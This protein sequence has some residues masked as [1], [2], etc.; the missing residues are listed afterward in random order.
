MCLG[1]P[2]T[3]VTC[4]NDHTCAT[5]RALR[6]LDK[7]NVKPEEHPT[8]AVTRIPWPVGRVSRPGP[9]ERQPTGR[10]PA[11]SVS[12]QKIHSIPQ[13]ER[14]ATGTIFHVIPITVGD[15]SSVRDCFVLY[16]IQVTWKKLKSARVPRVIFP[17][18]VPSCPSHR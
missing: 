5:L 11:I 3:R 16:S 9:G 12:H 14:R 10:L 15:P 4:R 8:W 7:I 1:N 13:K 2:P 17:Y 6:V 18:R